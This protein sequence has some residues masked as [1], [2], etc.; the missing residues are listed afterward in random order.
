MAVD[1]DVNKP[2]SDQTDLTEKEFRNMA[3][4]LLEIIAVGAVNGK[5]KIE[6]VL[7]GKTASGA[8][9]PVLVDDTGK[10]ITTT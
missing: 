8:I 6:V 10:I 4:S 2:L 1:K 5:I 9:K 3:S 7:N